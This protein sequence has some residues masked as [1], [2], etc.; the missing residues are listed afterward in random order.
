MSEQAPAPPPARLP[1]SSPPNSPG[2]VAAMDVGDLEID[3]AKAKELILKLGAATFAE[4]EQAVAEVL[5]VGMPMVPYLKKA[6]DE[7]TDAE[8]VLRAQTTHSQL[9]T[10]NFESRVARFLSGRDDGTSF[11]GWQVFDA[12][13]EDT[14]ATRDLF[15]QLVRVHPDVL[16]SLDGTTRD[17]IVAIDQTAQRI[18]TNKLQLIAPTFNDCVA[19]LL[20]M[21]DPGVTISMGYEVS[22][23]QTLQMQM[24]SLQRATALWPPIQGL[25]DQWISRSRIEHRNVVLWNT[26][27]WDLPSGL[28]LAIRTLYESTDVGTLQTAMQVIS[29]FGTKDDAKELAKFIDDERLADVQVP[30]GDGN[31]AVLVKLG[32]SAL[33]AIAVLYKVP[34]KD[35]GMKFGQTHAKIGFVVDNAGYLPS[36]AAERQQAVETVKGWL[37]GEVSPNKPRS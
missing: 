34:L 5:K 35:I 14:L 21:V 20:P 19:L 37:S 1:Q 9:T 28:R 30:V 26:M 7:E 13:F 29:R 2:D 33:A 31:N 18:Q 23:I 27:N 24:G 15:I 16:K 11:D 17:R 22:L 10:G 12:V 32:D 36:Q 6:I 4:R 3:E 8:L 25:V